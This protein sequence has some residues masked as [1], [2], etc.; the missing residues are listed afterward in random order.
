MM[1][2]VTLACPAGMI[3]SDASGGWGCGAFTSKGEWFQL[4]SWDAVHITVKELLPI[5]IAVAL[6]RKQWQGKA[7]WCL[8]DNAAVV[9]I[10]RSGRSRVERA[11][12]LMRSLFFFLARWDAQIVAEHIPGVENG[13]ADALSWNNATSFHLQVPS[14]R[15]LPT[16]VPAE[17]LRSLVHEQPDWTSTSW[18]DSLASFSRRA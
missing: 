4:E 6:W 9:A 7:I 12:H 8:C 13:A 17:L 10:L 16:Q 3:T 14:A 2:N 11:M 18:T 5:V 15:A 1:A